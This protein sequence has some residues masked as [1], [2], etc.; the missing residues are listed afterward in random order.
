MNLGF[1]ASIEK[2]KIGAEIIPTFAYI[3]AKDNY[4]IEKIEMMA[5]SR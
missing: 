2:K 1:T 5:S 3:Q 4:N